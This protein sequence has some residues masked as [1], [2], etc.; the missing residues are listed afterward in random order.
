MRGRPVRERLIRINDGGEHII[1]L[2]NICVSVRSARR[3]TLNTTDLVLHLHLCGGERKERRT[4]VGRR[5]AVRHD[6]CSSCAYRG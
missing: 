5:P 6:R 4:Y 1:R 2:R 3:C